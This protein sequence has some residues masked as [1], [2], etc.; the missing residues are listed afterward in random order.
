MVFIYVST[1]VNIFM[2]GDAR[3]MNH[4]TNSLILGDMDRRRFT[5]TGISAG[6]G[7]GMVPYVASSGVDK[8]GILDDILIYRFFKQVA[9]FPPGGG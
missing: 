9:V 7:L 2:F 1:I 5:K 8:G 6:L 3:S 4:G